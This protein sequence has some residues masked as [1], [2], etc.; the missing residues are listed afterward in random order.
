MSVTNALAYL[1]SSSVMK[2]KSF[3]T[4]APGAMIPGTSGMSMGAPPPPP[5]AVHT[6]MAPGTPNAVPP[7][8]SQVTTASNVASNGATTIGSGQGKNRPFFNI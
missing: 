7:P 4:L 5:G 1:A 2:E 6:G 8:G 3:I